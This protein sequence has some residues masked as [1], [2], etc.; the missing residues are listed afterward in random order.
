MA[1]LKTCW[2]EWSKSKETAL[3]FYFLNFLK[4]FLRNKHLGGVYIWK[5]RS[6]IFLSLLQKNTFLHFSSASSDLLFFFAQNPVIIRKG[7]P[8]FP[9]LNWV[10]LY[11]CLAD[12]GCAWFGLWIM[13]S[14]SLSNAKNFHF[15]SW[16]CFVFMFWWVE[17]FVYG[18]IC[19]SCHV[20]SVDLIAESAYW[21]FWFCVM[22]PFELW[23][24]Q[25]IWNEPLYFNCMC[26]IL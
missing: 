4:F 26:I 5:A 9:I 2:T 25:I 12:V 14:V 13:V 21:D 10:V 17:L 23:E 16:V 7:N 1:K 15:C 11:L 3:C 22:S 20:F 19:W 24:T 8:F 18:Q 6:S